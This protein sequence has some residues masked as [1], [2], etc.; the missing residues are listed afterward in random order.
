MIGF[1][2]CRF[3]REHSSDPLD[4][5]PKPQS[6]AIESCKEQLS[7]LL[8]DEIASA[9]RLVVPVT[10][11]TLKSVADHVK[12]SVDRP[13]CV[14]HSEPL[15]FVYGPKKSMD[16]FT[17]VKSLIFTNSMKYIKQYATLYCH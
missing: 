12:S 8:K 2:K 7:W 10:A 16:Y 9:M 5:L 17:E 4:S 15:H 13:K 6:L 3:G 11:T 1:F 14:F